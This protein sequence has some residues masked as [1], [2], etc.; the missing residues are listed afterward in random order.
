MGRR[1][2]EAFFLVSPCDWWQFVSIEQRVSVKQATQLHLPIRK[3]KLLW[4]SSLLQGE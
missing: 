2:T 1:A 4:Q 3:S